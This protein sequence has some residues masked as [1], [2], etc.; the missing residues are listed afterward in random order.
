MLS[1]LVVDDE[2]I[3]AEGL[4]QMLQEAFQDQ[5]VVRRCYSLTEAQHL[6]E[7]HRIDILL[8]DIEMPH[9]SGLELHQ[10]VRDRWP[11]VKVIY[12][13]GYSD[14]EYV[15]QALE[16]NALAYVLKSEGDPVIVEAV[17]RAIQSIKEERAALLR[18]SQ[19]EPNR[20]S[21]IHQ[22]I[23]YA[24]HGGSVT[25]A[26]FQTALDEQKLSI[27]AYEPVLL[28]YCYG[29]DPG[30]HPA[31]SMN[32]IRRLMEDRVPL[33]LTEM[34]SRAFLLICQPEREDQKH[35]LHGMLENAQ[36]ILEKQNDLMTVCLM[37]EPVRWD[38]LMEAGE[39]L[40]EQVNRTSPGKGELLILRHETTAATPQ[41]PAFGEEWSEILE[42][43][44]KLNEYLLTGQK[45]LYFEEEKHLW[46]LSADYQQNS[47]PARAIASTLAMSLLHCAR[48]FPQDEQ[49]L[50]KV[51]RLRNIHARVDIQSVAAE[52]HQLAK[53]LLNL[54]GQNKSNRQRHL[55]TKVNEYIAG[56]MDGDLSLI[57]IAEAVHFH[58]VYL[59]RIYKEH[60]GISL[61]DY[62]ANQRLNTACLLLRTSQTQ[63]SAIAKATGFTSSNYFSRWFRKHIGR[64]PQEYRDHML[65]AK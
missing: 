49:L 11:M 4:Y 31:Q 28:G 17:Q 60:A 6:L 27:S 24:M 7:E 1:L 21:R 9:G 13:T 14:F 22:L 54:R 41:L 43:L 35:L 50:E 10:W 3:I 48:G 38:Q 53:M 57:A 45:D 51:E 18:L 64:T 59:S 15:R 8:S 46:V 29:E 42:S 25:P 58:P 26:Q 62:I 5:L 56:H 47:H 12:L 23:Y 37:D 2:I 19:E 33:L 40:L 32:L 44:R 61:S 52:L 36:L 55:V 65:N 63:I 34:T 39:S 30:F 20:S 16:Q